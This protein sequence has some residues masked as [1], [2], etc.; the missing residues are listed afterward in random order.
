MSRAHGPILKIAATAHFNF[1]R[2]DLSI[3]EQP[4]ASGQLMRS[5]RQN[6][7]CF[8]PLLV[9]LRQLIFLGRLND[10]QAV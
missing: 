7:I 8:K 2:I 5:Y 6:Y 1:L 3:K 10:A 9:C 4:E